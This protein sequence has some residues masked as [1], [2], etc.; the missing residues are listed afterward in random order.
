MQPSSQ[1]ACKSAAT[2]HVLSSD[3]EGQTMMCSSRPVCQVFAISSHVTLCDS[4]RPR[5]SFAVLEKNTPPP[6]PP[7]GVF[8]KRTC[9]V[10]QR[11]ADVRCVYASV[12]HSDAEQRRAV[13]TLR[14]GGALDFTTVVSAPEGAGNQKETLQL[15][16]LLSFQ[17][18]SI[19]V[20]MSHLPHSAAG[21]CRVK[22]P[23]EDVHLDW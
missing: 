22:R 6:P 9:C 7:P 21:W 18:V 5:M 19:N 8:P 15:F 12:G 14:R 2:L 16:V 3:S 1:A 10:H 20:P 11:G 4:V 13:D 17:C 23:A